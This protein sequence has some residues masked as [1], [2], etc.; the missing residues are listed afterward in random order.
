MKVIRQM[1]RGCRNLPHVGSHPGTEF[2]IVFIII[3]A[4]AGTRGGW[5]GA[6]C[7]AVFMALFIVP[8]YLH[9]AYYRAQDSDRLEKRSS[10]T[11]RRHVGFTPISTVI[12]RLRRDGRLAPNE[13]N[14]HLKG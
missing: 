3:G 12:L 14:R 10:E 4:L 1:I 8:M 2:L 7:G 11:K 13:T 6:L 5:F 9:G